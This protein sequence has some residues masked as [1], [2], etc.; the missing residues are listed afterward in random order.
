MVYN[1]Y[2]LF[3]KDVVFSIAGKALKE[4]GLSEPTRSRDVISNRAYL[5]EMAYDHKE[6]LRTVFERASLYI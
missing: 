6:L 5:A 2:L 4:Y 3:F 1:Q